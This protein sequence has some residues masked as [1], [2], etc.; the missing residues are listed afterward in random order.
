[1]VCDL[2]AAVIARLSPNAATD[3]VVEFGANIKVNPPVYADYSKVK[4]PERKR[5][6]ESQHLSISYHTPPRAKRTTTSLI[7]KVLYFSASGI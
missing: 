3:K 4:L 2:D 5:K 6:I 1:M 7:Y